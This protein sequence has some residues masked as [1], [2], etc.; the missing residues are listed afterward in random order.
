M[1]ILYRSCFLFC[2]CHFIFSCDNT[3][4]KSEEITLEIKE[5]GCDKFVF[6]GKFK[7]WFEYENSLYYPVVLYDTILK[8]SI[9]RDCFLKKDNDWLL[10]S[11]F[12]PNGTIINNIPLLPL[13]IKASKQEVEI[14]DRLFPNPNLLRRKIEFKRK[15]SIDNNLLEVQIIISDLGIHSTI[16]KNDTLMI[17]D[18]KKNVCLHNLKLNLA[19]GD[20]IYYT[21]TCGL[22]KIWN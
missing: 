14:I 19:K 16:S 7:D 8:N 20:T 3:I 22:N 21:N 15:K 9:G 11:E 18:E 1:R 12:N 10:L 2:I 5:Y 4:E 6:K 13:S 17:K